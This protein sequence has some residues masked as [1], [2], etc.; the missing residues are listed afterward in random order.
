MHRW[1]SIFPENPWISIYTWIAFCFLPFFFIFKSSSSIE[2]TIG[3]S[4]LVLFFLSYRFSFK[5]QSGFLYMWLGFEMF[6][7]VAMSLLFGFVYFALF[8][9]F[10]IGN[11][12]HTTG[13]FIMYG[14]H[15]ATTSGAIVTGLFLAPELFLPQ[16]H[17]LLLS[18]IGTV[19][20][21][22]HLYNRNKQEQLEGQLEVAKE[23]ISEL[24]VFE[25][26][27][28]IA[29]DLHDTL[30]HKLSLIGL[31]SDL[32]V[33]LMTQQ[34]EQSKKELADIRSTS[35]IALKEVRELVTDMRSKKLPEEIVRVEQILKAAEMELT[36]HGDPNFNPIA[37]VAEN[38]LCMCMKEA[39][40]NIVKHSYG[41]SSD[42]FFEQT[43]DAFIITIKDDGIGIPKNRTGMPGSGIDGIRE[44]LD[45]VNGDLQ[46][47]TSE[48]TTITITVPII[49][50][51]INRGD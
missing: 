44:R 48:G 5:S 9:A 49:I 31:K 13:F 19:L 10:F 4:L 34:P 8:T 2:I 14:L 29:R 51:Q 22:F 17:F 38:V 45:F 50:K 32:A 41:N 25:E 39:V 35:S 11:I 3:I 30:G 36:I 26:R 23:R 28:R 18:L 6:I 33:K 46:I 42:I 37:P 20:L 15:I 21:P 43:S 27:Q 40:T 7:N 1:Y 16:I 47:D 24:I 12:R